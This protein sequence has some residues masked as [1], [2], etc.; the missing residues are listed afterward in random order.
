MK[1][2]TPKK[3]AAKKKKTGSPTKRTPAVI[4]RILSGL[5]KGTPLT[6]LCDS[7]DMPTHGLVRAWSAK[8]A[9]LSVNIAHA[10][11]VGFDRI[12][13][14]ALRI[15]DTTE[16]GIEECEKE[17]GTEIKRADMLGH[18]RLRVETRLK[19]LAKWDPKRYGE[20]LD[21]DHSGSIDIVAVIG[22][23]EESRE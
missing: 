8:D 16:E 19:L 17:W 10:R 20:R 1:A 23:N 13:H 3:P 14:D 9:D 15:A 21:I 6:V 7:P 5:S 2:P 11:E 18:R 12:A 4:R 22:G